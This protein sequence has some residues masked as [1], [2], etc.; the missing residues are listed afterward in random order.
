MY[1]ATRPLMQAH[2]WGLVMPCLTLGLGGVLVAYSSDVFLFRVG[3]GGRRARQSVPET[4]GMGKR[5]PV[6]ALGVGYV[7]GFM[8]KELSLPTP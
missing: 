3:L 1:S 5:A 8:L 6:E 2:A 4:E 7:I